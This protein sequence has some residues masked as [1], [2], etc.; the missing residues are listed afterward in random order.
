MHQQLFYQKD[1][2][3]KTNSR[4]LESETLN[5]DY[6]IQLKIPKLIPAK[7]AFLLKLTKCQ[8]AELANIVHRSS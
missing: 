6:Y 7:I 8:R 1:Y 3:L 5:K 2:T 4:R